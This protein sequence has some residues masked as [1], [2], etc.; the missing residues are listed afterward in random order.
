[1]KKMMT[2]LGVSLC[3]ALLLVGCTTSDTPPTDTT[4]DETA[5]QLTE[6]TAEA[7][8]EADT[9]AETDAVVEHAHSFND[10]GSCECGANY[11]DNGDGTYTIIEYDDNGSMILYTDFDAEGNVMFCQSIEIEYDEDGNLKHEKEYV[12]GVL[13]REASYKV[14]GSGEDSEAYLSEETLYSEDGGKTV[15]LYNDEG[16]LSTVTT[17]DAEGNATAVERYEYELDAEGNILKQ[18]QY[19]DDVL[20]YVGT[21]FVGADGNLYDERM[22]FYVEDGTVPLYDYTFEYTFDE[23]DR[24]IHMVEKLNG[25]ICYEM[26]YSPDTEGD[27][28]LSRVVEYDES[29]AVLTD[30]TYDAEGNEITA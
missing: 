8:T 23:A 29:G 25:V 14:R 17:Y 9:E 16:N 15:S 10:E 30:I 12:N 21:A 1:M 26:Y 13:C 18:T 27:L 5:A 24:M 2:A 28:Y 6:T 3:A 20:C 4:N 22:T 19:V 11:Y 7:E